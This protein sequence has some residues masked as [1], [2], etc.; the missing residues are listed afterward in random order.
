MKASKLVC[1]DSQKSLIVD[2]VLVFQLKRLSS[3]RLSAQ[4]DLATKSFDQDL[5]R[6]P[7]ILVMMIKYSIHST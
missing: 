5:E 3:E 6:E 2:T 4:E 1:T 7:H